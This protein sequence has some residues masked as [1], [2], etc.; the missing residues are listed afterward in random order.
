MK[1]NQSNWR[2]SYQFLLVLKKTLLVI[3][4]QF[5]K[6][7]T[8]RH[9]DETMSR[10]E[11]HYRG[12]TKLLIFIS[13]FD[14]EV[15]K[16]KQSGSVSEYI[17]FFGVLQHR[18]ATC[19]KYSS[20][21]GLFVCLFLEYSNSNSTS[22]IFRKQYLLYSFGI[23]K[24]ETSF[25]ISLPYLDQCKCHGNR[26]MSQKLNIYSIILPICRVLSHFVLAAK[27][28]FAIL[29]VANCNSLL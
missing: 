21:F 25:G 29:K 20:M 8:C 3:R 19:A 12:N 23:L 1:R 4:C 14:M 27:I 28:H 6:V 24:V 9:H 2:L 11:S 17:Y 18:L 26:G 15:H 13:R 22:T 5:C 7:I 16:Y 10:S